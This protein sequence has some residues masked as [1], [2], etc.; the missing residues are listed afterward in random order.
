MEERTDCPLCQQFGD[1]NC[2]VEKTEIKGEPFESYMCFKC[3][4]TSNS[5]LAFDSEKLE[6][7]T[8]N[9]SALMNDL[10]IMDETRGIVWFPS[11][12]NMGE[13]G[14]I[15]PDGNVNDWYWYYAKVV[16]IPEE[17]MEM[18][19]GHKKRLDVENAEKFGQFEFIKACY[20][21][22][23]IEDTALSRGS[24]DNG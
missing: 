8:E 1:S 18:Y 22:G 20:S 13:K 5:Y 21:M 24:K 6:E 19:D 17:D 4:M 7:Y 12:I 2:F 16:E 15:Y 14:I 10:S 9:H 11:V 23:I 3:G